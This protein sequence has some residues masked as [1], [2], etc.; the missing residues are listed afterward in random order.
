MSHGHET[1]LTFGERTCNSIRLSF[2]DLPLSELSEM[3][4]K[5]FSM[6]CK[7][8]GTLYPPAALMN[9]Y[10]SFNRMICRKQD[11]R[12]N[13]TGVNET[14]FKI[15]EH[16]L[17]MKTTRAVNSAMKKSRD[18]GVE[19]KRRKVE[20][21]TY[22]EERRM[23]DHPDNQAN[24]ARGAQKRFA[25]FCFTIFLIRGNSELHG[26]KVEHFTVAVDPKGKCYLKYEEFGYATCFSH[27]YS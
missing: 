19:I 20:S 23:L 17:F 2:F 7:L 10:M 26:V 22:E 8:D 14:R 18:G 13:L 11:D 21:I 24:F 9:I 1:G 5:S 4:C 15:T 6:V 12:C 25:M 16:P 27:L 3:L